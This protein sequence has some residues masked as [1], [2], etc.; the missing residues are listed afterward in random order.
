VSAW[1]KHG[2]GPDGVP[3]IQELPLSVLL[4]GVTVDDYRLD[5]ALAEVRRI[6]AAAGISV[7]PPERLRIDGP[8]VAAL[9]RVEVDPELGSDSP[10][11]AEALR[12]SARAPAGT[13]ALVLVREVVLAGPGYPIWGLAGGVPVP[14]APGTSR[15]GV[16]VSADLVD[17]DPLTAGAV[18]AHEIGHA[19]GLYHTTESALV[20]AP[21][22]AAQALHDQL[23]DTP[24]CP[25]GADRMPAD[26]TLDAAECGSFDAGNLM[27]WAPGRGATALTP[28]QGAFAR[29]SPLAR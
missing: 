5:V 23:D 27:F 15:S 28:Q 17:H 12:L 6:W 19:L 13:L 26:G 22:T 24:E 21:G 7:D 29:R 20:T 10:M 11:V 16:V 8:P 2:P 14:P 3:P 1:I 18:I 25:P 4:V 9:V